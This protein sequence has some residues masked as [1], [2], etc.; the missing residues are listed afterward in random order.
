MSSDFDEIWYVCL[1]DQD[2][3]KNK[4]WGPGV[5]GLTRDGSEK[6]GRFS[7]RSRTPINVF[8]NNSFIYWARVL[9]DSSF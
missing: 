4:I 3:V 7:G 6:M 9:S 5:D 8:V 1:C 2:D